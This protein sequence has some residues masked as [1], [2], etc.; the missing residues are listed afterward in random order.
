MTAK[1]KNALT[2]A[3]TDAREKIEVIDNILPEK[4]DLAS[5]NR[6]LDP[7]SDNVIITG[8]NNSVNSSKIDTI[9]ENGW[10]EQDPGYYY[11]HNSVQSISDHLRLFVR[12]TA[13]SDASPDGSKYE[14]IKCSYRRDYGNALNKW[15]LRSGAGDVNGKKEILLPPS[16]YSLDSYPSLNAL[17][18]YRK[19]SLLISYLAFYTDPGLGNPLNPDKTVSW[20][21]SVIYES[22]F[23]EFIFFR[24]DKDLSINMALGII[25]DTLGLSSFPSSGLTYYEGCKG[26]TDDGK[27]ITTGRIPSRVD[28]CKE[29]RYI[30][31]RSSKNRNDWHFIPVLIADMPADEQNAEW[32]E[33]NWSKCRKHTGRPEADNIPVTLVCYD[34]ISS[35]SALKRDGK[36]TEDLI[37][38]CTDI[39]GGT[40]ST[41]SKTIHIR[42]FERSKAISRN[43]Y[44]YPITL[45]IRDAV[46]HAPAKKD[47]LS[48]LGHA[49]GIWRK[50]SLNEQDPAS[51]LAKDP[52]GYMEHTSTDCRIPLAYV[53]SIYGCNREIPLTLISAG[54][55]VI[56]DRCKEYLGTE[57]DKA[58][59][60]KFRG[61]EYVPC[62]KK[63]TG[64]GKFSREKKL[65]PI[66]ADA[67]DVIRQAC[68]SYK[69]GMN[70]S[71][72][73][74]YYDNITIDYD[75][76]KAYATAMF[77][78]PDIDW[79]QPIERTVRGDYLSL[80]DFID[81]VTH[82]IDP[83]KP[84]IGRV[85][86]HFPDN[87]KYPSLPIY[88]D[89][90]PIFVLNYDGCTGGVADV[91]GPEVYLALKLGATVH[92]HSGYF[93]KPLILI[94]DDG[95]PHVSHSIGN[96]IKGICIDRDRAIADKDKG[97]LEELLLKTM[98]VAVYGKTSQNVRNMNDSF[99]DVQRWKQLEEYMKNYGCSGITNPVTACLTTSIVRA[100][101][102]AACNQV[103][104]LGKHVYSVTTDGF[105]S[106]ISKED[107][108]G[109]DL[110]GL[111]E[112]LKE[113]RRSLT[114]EN[115]GDIW[116]IKHAQND[117]SNPTTRGNTS[118]HDKGH[119]M[120]LDGKPLEGVNAHNGLK[121]P[122]ESDTYEDRDWMMK[123]TLSRT[124][125]IHCVVIQHT[126]LIEMKKKGKKYCEYKAGKDISMAFDLKRKPVRSSFKTVHPIIDGT[127]YEVA[128]FDT[129]PYTDVNEYRLYRNRKSASN[130]LRTEADWHKYFLKVDGNM[131]AKREKD[132]DWIILKDCVMLCRMNIISIPN[133]DDESPLS[134]D[135]KCTWI[136]SH[137]T[138]NNVF[139]KNTWK[140]V[141]K[142][143]RQKNFLPYEQLEDKIAELD[144]RLIDPEGLAK[145]YGM[146]PARRGRKSLKP[147]SVQSTYEPCLYDRYNIKA[148][149]SVHKSD[150]SNEYCTDKI[151]A[152]LKPCN[153]PDDTIEAIRRMNSEQ[154]DMY[155][156]LTD[157]PY[158]G[159]KY[160]MRLYACDKLAYNLGIEA[161]DDR[162]LD[163]YINQALASLTRD[164]ST[165]ATIDNLYNKVDYLSSGSPYP[166]GTIT[167]EITGNRISHNNRFY[168]SDKYVSLRSNYEM[169][170][171][172]ANRCRA[173]S[174]NEPP[175]SLHDINLIEK[176]LHMIYDPSQREALS[177]LGLSGISILTGGPGTGKTS[178]IKGIV[179]LFKSRHPK[180]KIKLCAFTGRASVN[181]KDKVRKSAYT[182][183]HMLTE[184]DAFSP[185]WINSKQRK[186]INAD[187]VIID[188]ASLVDLRLTFMLFAALPPKA[189]IILCGDDDQLPAV[190]A[191]NVMHDL[192]SSG[193]IDTVKL[194][195]VHR[196][197]EGSSIVTNAKDRIL[198]GLIPLDNGDTH[199]MPVSSAENGLKEVM[200]LFEGIYS[201]DSPFSSQ[202][203]TPSKASAASI[204]NASRQMLGKDIS[205][206][207]SEGDKV[208]FTRNNWEKGYVNG[209][210]GTVWGFYEGELAVD[211]DNTLIYLTDTEINDIIPAYACTVHKA[212]GG[213]YDTVIL[214]LT[215]NNSPLLTR[216]MLYTA[217]TR[218]KKSVYIVY[219]DSA[220]ERAL[221][222]VCSR[223]TWLSD[224]SAENYNEEEIYPEVS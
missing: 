43:K 193:I 206:D 177:N 138:S 155:K 166:N 164:G 103:S 35:L 158:A 113:A 183:H 72:V 223:D 162:R 47:T 16:Y 97:S 69:G 68:A 169:E 124:G 163:T 8:S 53:S 29:A 38:M 36:T 73:I 139:N 210:M 14:Q 161:W 102:I 197:G 45:T 93:L 152:L 175:V 132:K 142:K 128:N 84:F 40:S 25:F 145:V 114:E 70:I 221:S 209:Q 140:D 3:A 119:P 125:A 116:E 192:I 173:A 141:N 170:M 10:I 154:I 66:S 52:A 187:L 196:Q 12:K 51:F 33:R 137:N 150:S 7:S 32:R 123:Q 130:A 78:V 26:F 17:R 189:R 44:V 178:V 180:A 50:E 42:T 20:N 176:K 107:L 59:D 96:A 208:M 30:Y 24:V 185:D 22:Y 58:F 146:R 48:D 198:K 77:I 101:L 168:S 81:P 109:L 83:Y 98:I 135:E 143:D 194:R 104:E 126:S 213:E 159:L 11:G 91:C 211:V 184:I 87:V 62:G 122:Y 156:I 186:L 165:R 218:A 37:Q 191:G 118:R 86:F 171:S 74:G 200:R 179:E 80:D 9:K 21:F 39:N 167:A 214:S 65:I 46:C 157:D 216:N 205:K 27:P 13:I 121:S 23:Y 2:S 41:Y 129:V 95:K 54:T 82:K 61:M 49:V 174:A 94:G 92:C 133:L 76:I 112:G 28:A 18:S 147:V 134:V 110:Y 181:M 117:L 55:N 75:M 31:D 144:G 190:G 108:W 4:K 100:T 79:E 89:G 6:M 212:Q 222:N 57:S 202:I 15:V 60:R 34:G 182:I 106:D 224:L 215:E 160:G 120:M 153:V 85:T 172:I 199:M 90:N 64:A 188:E 115:K 207:I 105:I 19:E 88:E 56:R 131:T 219:T 127:E 203:L 1:I 220:M 71:S 67:A 149:D 204:N 151:T 99:D 148:P 5:N 217:I 195:Y 111:S 63:Q 136:M 201:E